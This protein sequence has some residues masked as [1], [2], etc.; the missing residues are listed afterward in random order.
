[1][2]KSVFTRFIIA[3][4][5]IY[6]ISFSFLIVVIRSLVADYSAEI[7]LTRVEDA[8][9]AVNSAKNMID[10]L[11]S[12]YYASKDSEESEE[13]NFRSYL[14]SQKASLYNSLAGFAAY[15]DLVMLVQ[16]ILS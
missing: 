2:F 7:T 10:G 4:T 8:E 3:F 12:E 5:L 15:R 9:K 6:V 11:Y 14:Y 1:M 16:A 13:I